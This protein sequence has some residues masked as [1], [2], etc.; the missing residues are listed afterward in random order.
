M[1]AAAFLFSRFVGQWVK[2][3]CAQGYLAFAIACHHSAALV[4]IGDVAYDVYAGECF[5]LLA[6]GQGH[7]EQQFIVREFDSK[8][9]NF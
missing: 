4:G 2:A 8:N 5:N 3:L 7:G 1:H 6:V 9:L